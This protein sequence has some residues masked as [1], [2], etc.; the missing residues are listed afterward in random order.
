MRA[1]ASI[2]PSRYTGS[3]KSGPSDS[4]PLVSVIITSYNQRRFVLESASSAQRQTYS[5]RELIVVDD[6]S[7]D[8]SL[9]LLKPLSGVHVISKSNR[10]VSAARNRG[11]Q[12]SSGEYIV[13]LDG[14][15]RLAPD[16]VHA[17]VQE[18]RRKTCA[19]LV[20]GARGL[21]DSQGSV[22]SK[23]YLCFPRRDYFRMFLECNPIQCPAAAMFSREA[24][25]LAGP[26]D[27]DVEPAKDYDMFL[28]VSYSF[29]VIRH[30]AVIAE[31]RKHGE[32][33]SQRRDIMVR[34]SLAVLNKTRRTFQ[35]TK[36]EVRSLRRG[37]ARFK[38]TYEDSF[39]YKGAAFKR[40]WYRLQALKH[41]DIREMNRGHLEAFLFL[42]PAALF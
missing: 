24:L 13:F 25:L 20:F 33:A 1:V 3:G 27:S 35:L 36:A 39:R 22:G 29:H 37:L 31:Y 16:A 6:G 8:G 26:F 18:I 4:L 5:N 17:H 15:D 9:E 21:I 23:P 42:T 34:S 28:R 11:F 41:L 40:L 12:E 7:T 32:S 10:G 2:T 14:D 30:P 38:A 19:G